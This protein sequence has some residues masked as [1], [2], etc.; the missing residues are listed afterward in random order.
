[1]RN[2]L[3]IN[4]QVKIIVISADGSVREAAL[5]AGAARFVQ[6]PASIKEILSAVESVAAK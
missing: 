4:P 3:R 2:I 1:M 6:K 5:K